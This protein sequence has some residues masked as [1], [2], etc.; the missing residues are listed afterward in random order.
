MQFVS[1]LPLFPTSSTVKSPISSALFFEVKDP[2]NQSSLELTAKM[3]EPSR[4]SISRATEA[5][6][7]EILKI[8]WLCF[9]QHVRNKLMGCPTEEDLPR[10]VEF[11]TQVMREQHHTV[12]VKVVDD[13]TGKI[14]A[15]ALWKI[16][17]S[18]GAPSLRDEHPP[19]WLEG[20]TMEASKKKL[21]E[22]NE[23]RR[24]AN[25]DG[26]LCR[27]PLAD[28]NLF[29][30]SADF[31]YQYRSAQLFYKLGVSPPGGRPSDNAMGVRCG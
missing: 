17:L 11:Y 19:P 31:L 1:L 29:S 9:P 28:D 5:D 26:F 20:E 13:S 6:L 21:G 16:Y 30:S 14:A 22:L 4:F 8:C 3:S 27:F 15:A 10:A 24:K 12:W 25:P 18:M 2:I 23:A 7:P